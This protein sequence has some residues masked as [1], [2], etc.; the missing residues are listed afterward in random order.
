MNKKNDG[1]DWKDS[2]EPIMR[3]AGDILL[4]YFGKHLERKAKTSHEFVTEADLKSEK[5]LIESLSNVIPEA[6]FMAEES[7]NNGDTNN[8]YCWVID[9]LDG[10]T[11]F[12]QG[13]PY[14]CISVALTKNNI[15][16]V[17]AIFN[18]LLNEFFYA[19]K[20]K[21]AWLNDKKIKVS[22]FKSIEQSVIAIGLPYLR[23]KHGHLVE[24]IGTIARSAYAIRHFGAIALD[25]ANTA[26]GRFDGV[27]FPRLTWWDIA[28]GVLLA[29]EAGGIVTDFDNKEV[30]PDYISCVA[31]NTPVHKE[32]IDQLK[33]P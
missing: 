1:F 26:C 12:A 13:L 4:S 7:G 15:P 9:P 33:R 20:G 14:F 8:G 29:Q 25:L 2:I 32:L 27:F 24:A 5:Y 19:E 16:H 21:G 10:T 28:A 17:G 3:K 22:D 11:N 6:A 31:A 18:P 30:H 23:K